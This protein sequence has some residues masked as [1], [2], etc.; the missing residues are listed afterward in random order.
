MPER[1]RCVVDKLWTA[2]RDQFHGEEDIQIYCRRSPEECSPVIFVQDRPVDIEQLQFDN[3]DLI[4]PVC[5]AS[6]K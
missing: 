6:K 4:V 2:V 1:E 5:A 3:W